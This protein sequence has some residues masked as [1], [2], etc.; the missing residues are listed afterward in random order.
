MLHSE[1]SYSENCLIVFETKVYFKFNISEMIISENKI[2]ILLIIPRGIA[3]GQDEVCNVYCYN[4]NSDMEW[5]IKNIAPENLPGYQVMPFVGLN[6][7]NNSV[8]YVTDF[9]GRCFE[10]NTKNGKLGEMNIVK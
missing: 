3:L 4:K 1:I 6:L 10:V 8:L 9:M 5:Q 2:F 7:E